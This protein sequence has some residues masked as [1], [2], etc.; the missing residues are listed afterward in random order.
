MYALLVFAF[1]MDETG[2][3]INLKRFKKH[4]RKFPWAF[5]RKLIIVIVLLLVF[6]YIKSE[7]D[8]K[9]KEGKLD[10]FEGIEVDI[11]IPQ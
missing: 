10:V 9:S 4:Q 8:K 3:D 5:I 11:E 6:Y 1:K 2:S 7:F